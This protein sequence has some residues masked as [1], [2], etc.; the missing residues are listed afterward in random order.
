[1]IRNKMCEIGV[2]GEYRP[3][4]AELFERQQGE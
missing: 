3:A 1:V 4:R 2:G